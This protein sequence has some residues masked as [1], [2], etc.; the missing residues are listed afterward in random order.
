MQD[1]QQLRAEAKV[2]RAALTDRAAQSA[3]IAA[4]LAALPE[5]R[6]ARCVFSYVAVRD[7]VDVNPLLQTL[8]GSGDKL[9]C[10][11]RLSRAGHMDAVAVVFAW[12]ELVPGP[13]GLLQ[14]PADREP[15]PP[16]SI[17]LVIV[18]GLLFARD[19]SRLGYGG[20]YY[21]RYLAHLPQARRI[22][23]CYRE[24]LAEQL[25][26]AADEPRCDLVITPDQVLPAE[27][28]RRNNRG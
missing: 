18:P 13:F 6:Q 21:D 11:P 16:A 20:G 23:L 17:D 25:P 10:V 8:I 28:R 27:P 12:E 15:L 4:A 3:A 2:K 14:P 26:T 19:G 24:L 9:L 7:E 5:W 1:K 22:G